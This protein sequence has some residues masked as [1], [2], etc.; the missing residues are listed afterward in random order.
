MFF[1]K[2]AP[3]EVK[4]KE[5][6]WVEIEEEHRE[7]LACLHHQEEAEEQAKIERK[8]AFGAACAKNLRVRRTAKKEVSIAYHATSSRL[9]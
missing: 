4:W 6:L 5:K 3:K 2:L 8:R 9:D 1:P 7:E